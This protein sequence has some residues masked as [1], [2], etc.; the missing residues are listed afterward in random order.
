MAGGVLGKELAKGVTDGSKRRL[1]K[2]ESGLWRYGVFIKSCQSSNV[3][4][5]TSIIEADFV[6]S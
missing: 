5:W 1:K 6:Q 2:L 3:S 4:V